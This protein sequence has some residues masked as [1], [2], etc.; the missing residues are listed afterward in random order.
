M[1]QTPNFNQP[2]H[3]ASVQQ[4]APQSTS[5]LAIFSLLLGIASLL[6]SCVTGILGVILGIVALVRI[7]GSQGRIGGKGLAIAG[8]ALSVVMSLFS[9]LV[10]AMLLPAVQQVRHAA[11]RTSAANEFREIA[12]SEHYYVDIHKKISGTGLDE[13]TGAGLSWRVHLLPYLEH[14]A[15]YEKFKL[16]EPWDSPHNKAL[17]SEMP[18]QY[19]A[20]LGSQGEL[21]LEPGYTT[22]LRPVGNGAFPTLDSQQ[23]TDGI[24]FSDITDGLSNTILIV[25][26]DPSE[27]VIWTDPA[28]DYR[29]DPADPKR[30]LGGQWRAG[31]KENRSDDRRNDSHF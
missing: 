24:S 7:N 28:G 16:D 12:I 8:I 13:S 11:R 15:L 19:A 23:R 9:G 3:P 6:F 14:Q 29:Y 20:K 2:V 25:E 4:K 5:I 26:A 17:I 18:H 1:S 31:C 21:A 10:V 30:G 22:V 27:A